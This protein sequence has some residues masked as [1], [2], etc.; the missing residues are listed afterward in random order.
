M[1]R[2]FGCIFACLAV[3]STA[4][5][6][7]GITWELRSIE[8]QPNPAPS[9][10]GKP[11]TVKAVVIIKAMGSMGMAT[12][13]CEAEID[14]GNGTAPRRELL[15]GTSTV[16]YEF[17][18]SYPKPGDYT[19][20]VKGASGP[21]G[22]VGRKSSKLEVLIATQEAAS[23]AAA[24]VAKVKTF[25]YTATP[26]NPVTEVRQPRLVSAECPKGWTLAPGSQYGPRF[27]CKI[28]PVEPLQCEP[29]SS[30]FES[31]NTIGCR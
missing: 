23:A 17:D 18:A 16:R 19:L 30:Y 28:L 4:L 5:A 21:R 26:K 24:E 27:T 11:V 7:P 22:C 8:A 6:A 1:I 14:F 2:A 13:A 15:G 10:E 29:G 25:V 20:S 31:G 12:D 3:A 9:V